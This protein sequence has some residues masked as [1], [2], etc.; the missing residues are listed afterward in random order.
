VSDRIDTLFKTI[1]A[2]SRP[3]G[4]EAEHAARRLCA[5]Y[6]TQRGFSCTERPFT[7]SAWPGRWATPTIG[8]TL[9]IVAT[10]LFFVA[11][12]GDTNQELLQRSLGIAVS[13]LLSAIV[14]GWIALRFGTTSFPWLRRTAINLE[15]IRDISGDNTTVKPSVHNSPDIWLVAHLDS[16]SQPI[17]MALR[18]GAVVVSIIAWS[19][20]TLLWLLTFY[21]QASPL[22]IPTLTASFSVA[23]IIAAIP[24]AFCLTDHKNDGTLDNASG[25]AVLLSVI[26]KIGPFVRIGVLLTSAEELGLAGARAWS[27]EFLTTSDRTSA[28]MFINCDSVDDSGTLTCMFA[29]RY[30]EHF[31][32]HL[33]A[34]QSQTNISIKSRRLIPGILV[35]AVAFT[36]AGCPALTVS[37]GNWYSLT[38]IHSRDDNLEHMTGAGI[39]SA[40]Q[41]IA[42]LVRNITA[43]R[44]ADDTLHVVQ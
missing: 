33:A 34:A 14:F 9:L 37:L 6:L 1:G 17:P 4:S 15:A 43:T 8:W 3:A 27:R 19:G 7:Y 5:D 28:P 2:S 18:V 22:S 38:R 21:L 10:F 44:R 42:A 40:A 25:V 23:A 26:D 20:L 12:R 11:L 35:D 36:E 41:F 29:R 32:D 16:K 24:L 39:E 31:R 30:R 13:L